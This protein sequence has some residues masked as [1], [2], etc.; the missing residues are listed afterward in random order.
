M[1]EGKNLIQLQE[2]YLLILPVYLVA[3]AHPRS[4]ITE[5][6][7]KD[8]VSNVL[9]NKQGKIVVCQFAPAVRIN[10]AEAL[11]VDV[12]T[13][14]TGK[15][16]T[17]LKLL[18]FDYIFDT[19]FSADMTIVEEATECINR[20][21]DPEA[22]LPMFTSCYPAWINYIEKSRIISIIFIFIFK[23]FSIYL[24]FYTND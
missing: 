19:T 10:L 12:G 22:I 24:F 8:E 7:N 18:G 6:F 1:K 11:G 9:P 4:A 16:V 15:V 3:N 17:A 13:I 21:Y 2:N 5:H 14:S 20:L 23:F